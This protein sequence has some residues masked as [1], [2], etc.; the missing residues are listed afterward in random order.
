MDTTTENII[1]ISIALPG[2][3]GIFC[4]IRRSF[5]ARKMAGWLREKHEKEWNNLHWVAKRNSR[6]GVETIITKGSIS[7][8]EVE[9]YCKHDEYL[10]KATWIGLLISAI[11]LFII[12]VMQFVVSTLS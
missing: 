7:G 3:Y 9:E 8:P 6:A 1:A 12:L 4:S 2:L 5:N 10:E 11:L